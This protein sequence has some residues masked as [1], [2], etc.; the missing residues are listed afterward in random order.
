MPATLPTNP[1]PAAAAGGDLAALVTRLE[2][3]VAAMETVTAPAAHL[4]PALAVAADAADEFVRRAGDRGVD[5]DARLHDAAHLLERLTAPATLRAL[6]TLL[7]RLPE[8]E[9]LLALADQAPG[10]VA[11]GVD[12]A[13]EAMRHLQARG[14]DRLVDGLGTAL[15]TAAAAPPA[16]V[17]LGGAIGALRNP[18]VKR[19]LGLLLTFAAEFG[20]HLNAGTRGRD[21]S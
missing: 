12:A 15:V 8:L 17:G 20:R 16:P 13:D 4:T 19:A 1:P 3:A 10:L 5:I 14:L 21:R 18:D 9:R 11:M 7:D 6:T 2:R